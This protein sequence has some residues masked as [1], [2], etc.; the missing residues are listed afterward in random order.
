MCL[1]AHHPGDPPLGRDVLA[2]AGISLLAGATYG[3]LFCVGSAIGKGAARG[4]FL[5]L[6]LLLGA[7]G[8]FSSVL[9]PR[10]HVASLLGG[11]P[12]FELSHRASS[13]VLLVLVV[14]YAELA[15]RLGRRPA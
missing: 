1:V 5:A 15:I 6:D 7:G 4:F 11:A 2:T 13:I 3:A 8:G 10:G 12:A 9:V 14:V